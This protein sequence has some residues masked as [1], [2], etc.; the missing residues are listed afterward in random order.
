[1]KFIA[2]TLVSVGGAT[3][4]ILG[5]AKWFG[6]FISKRLLDNYKNKH[7]NDLEGIKK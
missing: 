5:L 3:V 4:I 2:A 6:D 1:M 7:E